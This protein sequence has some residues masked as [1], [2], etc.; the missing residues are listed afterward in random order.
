MPERESGKLLLAS[1]STS[2]PIDGFTRPSIP[3]SSR[4]HRPTLP[5]WAL[6][7]GTWAHTHEVE[8]RLTSRRLIAMRMP[9]VACMTLVLALSACDGAFGGEPD[10]ADYED[11]CACSFPNPDDTQSPTSRP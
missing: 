2:S 11:P 10:P 8:P 6:V 3:E 7:T 9:A 5:R 1:N 4:T